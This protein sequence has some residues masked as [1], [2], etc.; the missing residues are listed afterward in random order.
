[1]K[2]HVIVI[3][4]SMCLMMGILATTA[5]AAAA[6]VTSGSCGVSATWSYDATTKTLTI[7]GSGSIGGFV[8][9]PGQLQAEVENVEFSGSF[10]E[11]TQR[12]FYNFRNLTSI[13]IPDGIEKIG[14]DAFSHCENL[15]HVVIPVS[16]TMFVDGAFYDCPLLT[17]AGPIGS[18]CNIEF[19]W[20]DTIPAC[21]FKGLYS[22]TEIVFPDNLKTIGVSAFTGTGLTQ[23]EIPSPVT[24]IGGLAFSGCNSLTKITIPNTVT[25][26]GSSAIYYCPKLKELNIPAS[27]I[28]INGGSYFKGMFG[29]CTELE[30]I[31]VDPANTVYAS[32]D[33]ALFSKEKTTLYCVPQ[34][35]SSFVIPASVTKIEVGAFCGCT[36]L[37]EINIPYG[38]TSIS[39]DAFGGCT[40]LTKLIIP[41]SVTS[42][43][44][45]FQDCTALTEVTLPGHDNSGTISAP[46]LTTVKI[47]EGAK[48]LSG[49]FSRLSTLTTV[50]L[51][52]S[53]KELGP[54]TFAH[55]TQLKNVY[56]AG[57]QA[58]WDALT[59]ADGNQELSLATVICTGTGSEVPVDPD[60]PNTPDTLDV[61][62]APGS[63]GQKLTVQVQ[64]GH[65]LTIQ[66]RR[67][68]S[69]TISSVQAPAGV[70]GVVSVTV[71]ATAGSTIQ[72]WETADEM[73]FTNGVPDNQILGTATREL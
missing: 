55:C 16:A 8:N 12:A 37:T 11:L 27:V 1:M 23:V 28:R 22:L 58:Q 42:T 36:K 34:G 3:I 20:T 32:Q 68:G 10:T 5:W 47:S 24:E 19:G 21:A 71:S 49:T 7:N 61:S 73:T 65:W 4:L 2:K 40:S 52:A 63:L 39:F 62:I 31:T 59:I 50:Y 64:S 48:R 14:S 9:Y 70:G 72:V 44:F 57:T 51:P 43:Y 45:D 13:S 67:A 69:I 25:T 38:V 18:N 6:P 54:N 35:K 56:F 53:L 41:N 33:G 30:N 26:I 15:S 60:D 29:G 17:T 66:T 46:S